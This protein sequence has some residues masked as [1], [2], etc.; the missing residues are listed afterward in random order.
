MVLVRVSDEI[1][2]LLKDGRVSPVVVLGVEEL[3]DGT[4]DVIL[5]TP[6]V[7]AEMIEQGTA[8]VRGALRQL[9]NGTIDAI[10][11]GSLAEDVLRAAMGRRL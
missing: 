10:Q 7:T 8:E 1:L 9:E 11:P 4:Y 5:Q 2:A 3:A 6:Q